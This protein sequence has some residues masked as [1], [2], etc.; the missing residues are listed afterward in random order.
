MAAKRSGS[1][2]TPVK[3]GTVEVIAI[4]PGRR[5]EVEDAMRTLHRAE[6]IKRDGKLMSD[7]RVHAKELTKAAGRPK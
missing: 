6:Q 5:Y 2:R 7:V 1:K 3:R 4:K